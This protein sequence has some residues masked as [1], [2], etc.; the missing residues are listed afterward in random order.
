MKLK[1]KDALRIRGMCALMI[2]LSCCFR[3]AAV[4]EEGQEMVREQTYDSF[5]FAPGQAERI[6]GETV[7]QDP[8]ELIFPDASAV[9]IYNECG[10]EFDKEALLARPLSFTL[11]REP[12]VLIIHTHGSEAYRDSPDYRSTD[13]YENMIAVGA[14]IA[15]RLNAAGIPTVQD[16]TLHDM[17][18]GYNDAYGQA[19]AA[20]EAWLEEYPSIQVVID[21]H[22]DAASD[23]A[24]EQ[25]PLLTEVEGQAM[26]QLMLVMGTD[27]GELPH[28]NWQENLAFA[29][30]LQAYF[31]S[32]APGLMR[33]MS[34]RAGRYNQHMTPYSVLLEVGSAGNSMEEALASAAFAGDN[35]AALLL[36]YGS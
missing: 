20:I 32:L 22:R 13:P 36:A 11:S 21:V 8:A 14:Q 23:N 6:T 1:T 2:L 34:L 29:M 10:A 15:E 9:E 25:K 7:L 33:Q 19:A 17:T 12:C 5:Y 35:L 3:T 27:M 18:L 16:T 26:A 31:Q 24:G 4:L 28:E 30:K